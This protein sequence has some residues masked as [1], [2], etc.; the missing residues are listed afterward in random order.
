MQRDADNA[1]TLGASGTPSF[2]V[3]GQ[4][5]TSLPGNLSE[6]Q[7]LIQSEVDAVEDT[8]ALDRLTGQMTVADPSELD[9]ETEPQQTLDVRVTN[10]DG[11][12]EVITITVNLRDVDDGGAGGVKSFVPAA[13]DDVFGNL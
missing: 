13:V 5:V 11:T 10:L 7:S 3:N 1:I 4:A 9:F 12:T 6:F 2:Y 8:F